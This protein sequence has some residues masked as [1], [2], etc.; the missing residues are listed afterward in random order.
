MNAAKDF[1]RAIELKPNFDNAY[2]KRGLAKTALGFNEEA[3]KDYTRALEIDPKY[4]YAYYNRG[5][6]K[7]ALG[8]KE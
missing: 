3:I 7:S 4:S 5:N 6:A 1:S 8:E 2:Y